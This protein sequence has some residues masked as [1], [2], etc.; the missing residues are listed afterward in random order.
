MADKSSFEEEDYGYVN[1]IMSSFNPVSE[2]PGWKGVYEPGDP[3][4]QDIKPSSSDTAPTVFATWD[5]DYTSAS[6]FFENCKPF[7]RGLLLIGLFIEPNRGRGDIFRLARL[8]RDLMFNAAE[9]PL[10]LFFDEAFIVRFVPNA[11]F[12]AEIF[13]VPFA[14]V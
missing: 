5:I 10:V 7:R 3:I 4:L 11:A 8:L 6:G 1:G 13:K 9:G 2:I 12:R 14:G